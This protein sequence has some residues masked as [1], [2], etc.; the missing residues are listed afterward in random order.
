MRLFWM[1]VPAPL[2]PALQACRR[3]FALAAAFSALINI[4]YLA[5][6][7]YMM[8]VYDRVVPTGG[9]FT[10]LW[11]TILVA[12]A[13]A[14]LSALEAV[15]SALMARVSLRLDRILAGDILERLLARR[16]GTKGSSD[17]GPI[18]REFDAMRAALSGQAVT[19]LFDAPWTPIYLLVAF[20]IHPVLGLLV[21]GAGALLVGLAIAHARRSKPVED[22]AKQANNRSYASQE[23]TFRRAEIVRALGMRTAMIR[24]HLADRGE[25]QDA[26]AAA[27]ASDNRYNAIVKF[28]RMF[29]Q[30]AALAAGGWLAVA[31]EIS[32]GAI[33][34]ASVLLS[35]A[36]QP[37]EQLV[38]L[39]PQLVQG[40][41]AMHSL[42]TLFE[43]TGEAAAQR[44]RL[45]DPTGKVDLAC[46]VVRSSDGAALLL[47]NISFGLVPGE[48]C[49]V[50]GAS[51]AGKTTLAR[52]VAGAITPDL[53]EVRID[54][55]S[56]S[57]WDA[58]TL[59]QHIGY[60]PQDSGLLP[61][62]VAENISRFACDR[63]EDRE[64][65]DKRTIAAAELAGVHK[66][67]LALPGGYET[68][69]GEG[70]HLLSAGQA[71]RIALARALYGDPAIIVLDEPN[72]ALDAEGEAALVRAVAAARARG[73]AI[74]IVAHRPQI[75]ANAEKLLVL[76]AGEVL[77]HGP[78][79]EVLEALREAGAR[80]NVVPINREAG[81]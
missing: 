47:K 56:A 3:H 43:A 49:G 54:D 18:M 4:L 48:L 75:L 34:A 21:L 81:T 9:I 42:A 57:D 17:S 78:R 51:G 2:E 1:K 73:A 11:L 7:I 58:E 36:L 12:I 61:A 14:T 72:S 25:G 74:L 13:I 19:A 68:R 26:G 65:V 31:G 59:A 55:A 35:R 24:R 41:Q 62:T 60:L 33:I 16:T 67:I 70:A 6:T 15:R 64:R 39:W 71:Q 40:R 53:G 69:I 45:P 10:L 77:H 20:L 27:Q 46:V 52:V 76:T 44:M 5:P 8:Q 28:L 79:E 29:M 50:I 32:M 22:A 80:A 30:S 37:V 38:R 66:L 23:A 63:G